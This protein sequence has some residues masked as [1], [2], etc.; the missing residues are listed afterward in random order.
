MFSRFGP[1][2]LFSIVAFPA[3]QTI[4]GV[5]IKSPKPAEV[6]TAGEKTKIEF[7]SPRGA[8]RPRVKV[9]PQGGSKKPYLDKEVITKGTDPYSFE[10]VVPETAA[11]PGQIETIIVEVSLTQKDGSA[12]FDQIKIKIKNPPSEARR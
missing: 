9:L 5:S 4:A 12:T 10:I 2:L 11:G 7:I 8:I 3:S 1:I 6:W